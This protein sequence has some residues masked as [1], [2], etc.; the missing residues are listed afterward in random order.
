MKI[1]ALALILLAAVSSGCI[2]HEPYNDLAWGV[3]GGIAGGAIGAGTGAI[4]GASITDGV[5]GSSALLGT[6]IGV[7][8]GI[9]LAVGYAEY[10]KGAELRDARG[11]V[12]DNEALIEQ[13]NQ[14]I[15]QLRRELNEETFA[16]QTS[17]D[18]ESERLYPGP[19]LH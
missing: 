14:Q 9:I 19:T 1:K 12:E 4:I 13:R 16:A 15:E 10:Q 18:G 6:A 3:N 11:Q 8:A 17:G 7:P 2:S 5:V